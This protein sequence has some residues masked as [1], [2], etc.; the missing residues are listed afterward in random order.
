MAFLVL[1]GGLLFVRLL[2]RILTYS[3]PRIRCLI[4]TL[5]AVLLGI[6]ASSVKVEEFESDKLMRLLDVLILIPSL[7]GVGTSLMA[8]TLGWDSDG[9][10]WNEYFSIG[11]TSYGRTE[12]NLG[13]MGMII[14]AILIATPIFAF[15]YFLNLYPVVIYF[16]FHGILFLR[17]MLKKD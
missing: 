1:I 13:L 8:V 6:W 14:W 4:S 10:T 9:G 16:I 12:G 15:L 17:V 7:L 2:A 3:N 11:N 5:F